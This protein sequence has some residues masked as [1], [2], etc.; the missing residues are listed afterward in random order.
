MK[1]VLLLF[2]A[3]SAVTVVSCNRMEQEAAQTKD[4]Q[5]TVLGDIPVGF[6]AYTQRGMSTKAGM[7]GDITSEA[8]RAGDGFG[9]FAFYTNNNTYD[10]QFLPNFMY[11]EHLYWDGTTNKWTY[12]PIKFWPNE[13]GDRAESDDADKVTFFAYAP[14]VKVV[15]STGKIDKEAVYAKWGINSLTRNSASGDPMVKYLVNFDPMHS[16]DLLWGVSNGENWQRIYDGSYQTFKAGYPWIDV[17][18]PGQIQQPLKFTFKHALT[19]LRV[20]IDADPDVTEHE[21][22]DEADAAIEKGQT[23][24]YVRSVT[25]EGFATK[26][27]LNLNN[28]DTEPNKA[29]WMDYSNNSNDLMTGEEVTIYDGRKDGKEGTPGGMAS[30][31]KQLGLNPNI[32]QSTIWTDAAAKSGVTQVYQNLFRKAVDEDCS[33]YEAAGVND[34]V[35]V[36]PTGDDVKVTIVYD[37]ETVDDKLASYVSDGQTHGT[38]VENHIT[39]SITFANGDKQFENGKA[40][41][42]KLH[43]GLNSVKFDADV[44]D[45]DNQEEIDTWLP[46]NMVLYPAT[47]A[48]AAQEI[49]VPADVT[50]FDFAM[51]GLNASE[52][53]NAPADV[54]NLSAATANRANNSGI[55]IQSVTIAPNNTV[56]A[57]VN[58]NITWTGVSSD[59]KVTLKITQ[60]PHE[61]GLSAASLVSNNRR[62]M[63]ASTASEMD[64]EPANIKSIAVSRNGKA[65]E[66][67]DATPAAGQFQYAKTTS[68]GGVLLD[69]AVIPGDI[70]EITMQAG[71][72][73]AETITVK[74][75]GIAFDDDSIE[76]M[77]SKNP[78]SLPTPSVF[79]PEPS[80]YTWERT[81]PASDSNVSISA[82]GMIS[83]QGTTTTL[84]KAKV[85]VEFA[86]DDEKA[87]LFP[88]KEA[89]LSI[90]SIYK[91]PAAIEAAVDGLTVSG[92][93][94]SGPAS[95]TVLSECIAKLM[96]QIDGELTAAEGGSMTFEL[97]EGDT[98]C[99][100]LG[101][102]D[103]KL[104]ARHRSGTQWPSE[105]TQMT[106]KIKVTVTPPAICNYEYAES[107]V[108]LVVPVS[109]DVE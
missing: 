76:I 32:V 15:E 12:S 50:S 97:L 53:V 105:D 14:Y 23:R 66:K 45:W 56:L 16:V 73:K 74:I 8:L 49:N 5:K 26:G 85:T 19:K 101:A 86:G 109:F 52:S 7:S 34:A 47:E 82:D 51:T 106:L 42:I 37:V 108:T 102:S 104:E 48:G 28:T 43:L 88:S 6:E 46:S 60:A 36:I 31:E 40:Y 3:F 87:W 17:E 81:E 33:A 94:G 13:Y 68:G 96:G 10:Q 80:A 64:W 38:S 58:S 29:L 54:D 2:A 77:Y 30:N 18:R 62:I 35:Y 89:E 67:V 90:L 92:S 83:M 107:V 25:F 61:L 100:R 59:K 70:F 65:L 24:V 103:G 91:Q 20:L 41:T 4:Q 22:K 1:K 75:G 93:A 39:K 71:D 44:T 11:N 84:R 55:A 63:F 21:D 72:A 27:A 78:Q 95:D 79:G 9:V 99:F 69:V 57:K 98:E